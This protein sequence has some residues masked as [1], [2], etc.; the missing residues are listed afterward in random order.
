MAFAA[1]LSVALLGPMWA[2]AAGQ[3]IPINLDER[4]GQAVSPCQTRSM[5]AGGRKVTTADQWNHD[6]RPE[7]L[8]LFEDQVYGKVP[9]ARQADPAHVSRL[10]SE[11]K[12][13]L[14]GTAIR[15][16]ITILFSEK[17]DGPRMDLLL[18]PAQGLQGA[19]AAC[20]RFW[21]STSQGNHTIHSDPGITLARGWV[22][23]DPDQGVTNH[24]PTE[25]SRGIDEVAVAGRARSSRAATPLA[26]AY[27]GD[28]DPDYDDG[29]QNGIQP[30]FYQPGQTRPAAGRVGLD[31]SLGL[32]PEPGPRLLSKP[33]PRST[34]ARSFSWATRGSARRP[35]GPGRR[36]RDSR[37]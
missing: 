30:L 10:R 18:V 17:P 9:A 14:G 11:D 34:H 24:T 27:Y 33:F 3:Q 8:R 12:Q 36:I 1:A 25:S 7:L 6:R 37:S 29:F 13:A 16:E 35:S 28:I 23:N 22:P 5:M 26:T 19:R 2:R 21:G 15:R 20:R 31:R 4:K 32:G